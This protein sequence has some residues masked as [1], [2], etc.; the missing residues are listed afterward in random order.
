MIEHRTLAE[1]GGVDIGWLK[2]KHH[3]AI[4][5]YGNPT[6]KAV[7][8]LYV[9]NDDE[10]APRAGFSLHPH[11]DVEIITYVREGVITHEDDLG[12]KGRTKAG[13]VQVMS[14]GTGIRHSERNDEETPTR[15]F[16]IWI[17][18]NQVGN[19]PRWSTQPFPRSDRAGR[20]VPLASGYGAPDALPIRADAEV[21][22][23]V[24]AAGGSIKLEL[25]VGHDAYLVPALGSVLV[26]GVRVEAREG[27]ALRDEPSLEV[28]ALCDAEMVLVV[29][30]NSP[31]RRQQS[32]L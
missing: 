27:V 16:Q 13:D 3:F 4:G 26:N 28:E 11:A 12:N 24:L 20:F 6:H 23:A 32:G 22:G 17:K 30:A 15:I 31:T 29:A 9:W 1:I 10:I 2:A 19:P 7:G 25:K 18:P 5:Q 8:R 14:A 21:F